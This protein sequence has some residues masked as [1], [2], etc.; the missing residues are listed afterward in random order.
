MFDDLVRISIQIF[1]V[2][3]ILSMTQ[4]FF[5]LETICFFFVVAVGIACGCVHFY[6][7]CYF[8]WF[9]YTI[10][11]SYLGLIFNALSGWCCTR[12]RFFQ[13]IRLLAG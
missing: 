10:V 13:F 12:S 8:I 6:N 3:L 11:F 4:L 1:M 9:L 2:I 7:V 5:N